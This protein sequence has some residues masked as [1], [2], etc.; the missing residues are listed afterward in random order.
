MD[1]GADNRNDV[2]YRYRFGTAEFDE[3]A[4]TLKVDGTVV[5][6][7]RKPL[8]VLL[9]L[10]RHRGEIVTKDEML[11]TVWAETT[12]V[13]NVLAN[14]VSKLRTALGEENSARIQTQARIGYRLTGPV[15]RVAIGRKHESALDL[16]P[17]LAVPGREN[18][19]LERLLGRSLGSEVW[20]ARQAKSR[21]ITV[22]KFATGGDGLAALK[23]EVTLARVLR[24]SLGPRDDFGRIV[25]WN[26]VTPPFFIECEYGGENLAAWADAG[27]R[28]LTLP[29]TE[30]L[31]IFLQVADAVAAAHGVGVLHKDLKPANI[32]IGPR[33]NGWQ[34]RLTDFGSGRLLE[35]DRLDALSITALG[36]TMTEGASFD[37]RGGTPLYLA[38]EVLAGQ[39]P[40]MKSD[41]YAL[42]LILYQ[43]IVGDFAKPLVSGWERDVDDPFL[44]EDIA[45]ATDGDPALR[46]DSAALLARRL[47]ALDD[48]HQEAERQR[49]AAEEARLAADAVKRSRAR[50]PW[51]IATIGALAAGLVASLV[52]YMQVRSSA[53]G[54]AAQV[55]LSHTLQRFLTDDLIA[56]SK[57]TRSGRSDL[58]VADAAKAAAAKIDSTFKSDSPTVRAALHL[59]MERSFYEL[60]D[61][62]SALAEGRKALAA[63]QPDSADDR[64][65]LADAQIATASTLIVLSKLSEASE[66]L[67]AA[68]QTL[69]VSSPAGTARQELQVGLL[70]GR[71]WLAVTVNDG[72]GTLRAAAQAWNLAQQLPDL[73]AVRRDNCELLLGDGY[74]LLGRFPEAETAY[75]D[76]LERETA[77]YGA[78]DARPAHVAVSLA[79]A[80]EHQG[81]YEAAAGIL[82]P[83]LFSLEQALGP[84]NYMTVDAKSFLAEVDFNQ[85][86]YDDALILW[87]ESAAAFKQDAGESSRAYVAMANNIGMALHAQGHVEEAEEQFRKILALN[88]KTFGPD[89][90]LILNIQYY[91]VDTLL[92]LHRSDE[93]P[94][95]L[96]GLTLEGLLASDQQPDWDGRLA[97]QS[98]RL[99]L[100][101]GRMMEARDLLTKAAEIIAAKNPDGQISPAAIR[102]LIPEPEQAVR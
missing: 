31:S 12:T 36:L 71:S 101:Q 13:E 83:A 46:L 7:Q 69:A 54:L 70:M 2:L 59:E 4:F 84:D 78:A 6:V 56:A 82:R 23:R 20:I 52:L 67:D 73:P 9:L 19:V 28:L 35:P 16:A 45:E 80:M 42:G 10:L 37:S 24:E 26:F 93:V 3:A 97:Y 17:G 68:E 29:L 14:A 100:A 5:E 96:D 30:R 60:S 43:M 88:R 85:R 48:R 44:R 32:L 75:R 50:R 15:E 81:H 25:D 94:A 40:T 62:E 79:A 33:E 65:V 34:I 91:L 102:A 66:L 57:L 86:N 74:R 39:V 89:D 21:E 95:L 1:Q 72:A 55:N 53:L 11:D 76:V 63:L 99:A 61:F 77:L 8:E 38:P 58:T 41:V 51:V 92:D 49:L 98:G 27:N 18:F 64:L 22:Y 47:R 90:P 87:Q